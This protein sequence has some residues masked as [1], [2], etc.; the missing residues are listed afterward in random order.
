MD[1]S[2]VEIQSWSAHRGCGILW[3]GYALTGPLKTRI[4]P[5]QF[6]ACKDGVRCNA[7]RDPSASVVELTPDYQGEKKTGVKENL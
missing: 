7:A 4:I 3:H 2:V 1:I 6:R 5:Q